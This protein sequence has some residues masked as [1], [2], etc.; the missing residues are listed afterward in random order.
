MSE[1]LSNYSPAVQD[2]FLNPRNLG[3][4]E[5]PDGI[6]EVGAAACGDIMRISLRIKNGRIDHAQ[7]RTYG[8]GPAIASSSMTTELLKGRTLEEAR[9]LTSQQIMQ[10]L[11]GLPPAKA[12]CTILAEEAVKAA[13]T[14]YNKRLGTGSVT[15]RSG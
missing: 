13:L 1:D 6:A 3:D 4:I 2:H 5:Q 11:G 12:H 7:F 15:P 8:C 9:A 10:A 14:D